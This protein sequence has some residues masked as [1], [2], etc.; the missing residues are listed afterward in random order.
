MAPSYLILVTFLSIAPVL[1]ACL[2]NGCGSNCCGTCQPVSCQ[3]SQCQPGYSCGHYGCARNRARSALTNTNGLVVP[4]D[5]FV[6]STAPKRNIFGVERRKESEVEDKIDYATFSKLTNPNV[7]F[8]QCCEDRRLPDAC[9]TKCNF[10]N[11]NK[12]VLQ[13]MYFKN[14]ACPIEAAADIQYCAAQ[15]RDHRSCCMQNGIQNTIAGERCLTF[16]N[17]LPG[18]VVKLD[19][20]YLPC[21][22]RFETI[23]TCFYND[24]KSRMEHKLLPRLNKDA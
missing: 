20:S 10:N 17:Q 5:L 18:N 23:K 2:A 8:R 21:Y 11:Y 13:E 4:I 15:G 1:D 19:Y 22:D 7:L 24:I 6:N 3:Q 16:C 9:L 12:A 14:D